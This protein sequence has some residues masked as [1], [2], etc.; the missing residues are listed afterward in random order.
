MSTLQ[1]SDI[2]SLISMP[3]PAAVEQRLEAIINTG[4]PREAILLGLVDRIIAQ[5]GALQSAAIF[6]SPEHRTEVQKSVRT[7]AERARWCV[8]IA[9][10]EH[11]FEQL[12]EALVA[13]AAN[14][15]CKPAR[16]SLQ[17]WQV[18]LADAI[19]FD[20]RSQV[21]QA[22]SSPENPAS[23]TPVKIPACPKNITLGKH[24]RLLAAAV[25][26]TAELGYWQN[27]QLRE[28]YQRQHRDSI[29]ADYVKKWLASGSTTEERFLNCRGNRRNAEYTVLPEWMPRK[30]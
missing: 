4:I 23:P 13:I 14:V 11:G 20:R 25:Q 8:G 29:K 2:D 18:R 17:H 1:G 6:E 15:Y 3:T 7:L 30:I 22:G 10:D 5:I 12:Y 21:D 24:E 19:S 28:R 26:L 27:G 16:E 9:K